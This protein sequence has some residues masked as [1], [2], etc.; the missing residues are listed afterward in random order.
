M[1]WESGKSSNSLNPER[2][3]WYWFEGKK[4]NL[5]MLNIVHLC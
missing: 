4:L 2:R 3:E 1:E 5:M